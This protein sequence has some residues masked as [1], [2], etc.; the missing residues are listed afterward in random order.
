MS[1][2][3]ATLAHFPRRRGYTTPAED[4][5]QIRAAYKRHGW[6]SKDI[7]VRARS[8]SMGSSID[9]VVKRPGI[10]LAV[11]KGIAE[12]CEKIDRCEITGE[13][14]SGGNRFVSVTVDWQALKPIRETL[15]PRL[16][17]WPVDEDGHDYSRRFLPF[18]AGV[19]VSRIPGSGADRL[20]VMLP[21]GDRWLTAYDARGAADM[22]AHHLFERFAEAVWIAEAVAS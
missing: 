9:V 14:L 4:A 8:Y 6:S 10:P 11:V 13:I 22:V 7:S 19:T 21:G 1:T 20:A 18:V 16:E 12:T 2:T 3:A 5:A 17:A 15:L